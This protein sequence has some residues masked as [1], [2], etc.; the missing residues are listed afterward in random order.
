MLE[1]SYNRVVY[2]AV[3]VFYRK[4]YIIRSAVDSSLDILNTRRILVLKLL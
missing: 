2:S 4:Y 1:H 3:K